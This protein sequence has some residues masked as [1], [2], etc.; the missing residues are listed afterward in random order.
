MCGL[1]FLLLAGTMLGEANLNSVSSFDNYTLAY[2]DAHQAKKPML[3]ILNPDAKSLERPVMLADVA[4]TQHRRE[5]LR[6]FVVV[7]VDT[8]TPH[9]KTM[10]SLF[11]SAKLPRV[12]VI[13]RDQRWQLFKTS[14]QLQ[15]D[16]WNRILETFQAGDADTSLNLDVEEWC[17]T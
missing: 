8:K 14:R 12:V 15:G 2:R 16:D 7:V 13:D 6:N 5:L 9:G 3:V 11:G 10:H 4:K 17:P 1:G